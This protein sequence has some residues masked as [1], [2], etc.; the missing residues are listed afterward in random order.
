MRKLQILDYIF[1]D[2]DVII[3]IIHNLLPSDYETTV[4]RLDLE[5]DVASLSFY[6]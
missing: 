6:S 1:T 5:N 2:M 4:E 3:H